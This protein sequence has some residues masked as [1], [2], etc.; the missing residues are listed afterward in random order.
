VSP[1][2]PQPEGIP[3]PRPSAVSA[4]YWDG[5][6][7][8]ELRYQRCTACAAVVF[9]PSIVCP[10]CTG[11]DLAWEVSAGRGRLYSWTVVWR[12]QTPAFRVPYA[13]AIV[14]LD[15]GFRLV[16]SIIGCEPDDLRPDMEVT[17]EF[18]PAGDGVV[19]PYGRVSA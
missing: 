8:G 19:L 3:L 17:I 18:H 14:E 11:R 6:R 5:C 9:Q 15:E 16:T 12:P 10:A 13:P 4:P 1:L 2:E 7:A